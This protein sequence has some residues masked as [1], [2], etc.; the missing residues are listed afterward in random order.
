MSHGRICF[1]SISCRRSLG[2]ILRS[3]LRYERRREIDVA[4]FSL[5]SPGRLHRG[6][7]FPRAGWGHCHDTRGQWTASPR[8]RRAVLVRF[9]FVMYLQ[10]RGEQERAR[11]RRERIK[12]IL[13]PTHT[14]SRLPSILAVD[15]L[16]IKADHV[17]TEQR[18]RAPPPQL[19]VRGCE[20]CG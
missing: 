13:T 4:V 19:W 3:V 20:A 5:R 17:H 12:S 16:K 15:G 9:G 10:I 1:R 11:E 18:R 2:E 14:K 8:T 6:P 7:V